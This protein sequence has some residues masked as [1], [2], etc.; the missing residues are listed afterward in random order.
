MQQVASICC[1]YCQSVVVCFVFFFF[2][3][4]SL[5]VKVASS[6]FLHGVLS[7]NFSEQNSHKLRA[8]ASKSHKMSNAA[9][10][11][12]KTQIA[13]N[14]DKTQT[15]KRTKVRERGHKKCNE[16]FIS[17]EKL[18]QPAAESCSDQGNFRVRGLAKEMRPICSH[19][20]N[21]KCPIYRGITSLSPVPSLHPLLLLLP[22]AVVVGVRCCG[23]HCGRY[24]RVGLQN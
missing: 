12:T 11:K 8:R 3:P 22:G 17:R 10:T 20:C 6:F 1:C 19:R 24:A 21:S 23:Q 16:I 15:K 7:Q 2:S 18:C 5:V 4:A 13:K 14:E 9:N